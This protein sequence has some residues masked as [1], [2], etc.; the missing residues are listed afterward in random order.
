MSYVNKHGFTFMESLVGLTLFSL[1]LMLYLPAFY[2]E[3]SR[4]SSLQTETQQWQIFQKLV[5]LD[6]NPTVTEQQFSLAQASQSKASSYLVERFACQVDFCFIQFADGE[7]Y[8]VILENI[9]SNTP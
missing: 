8:H 4:I 1:I 5:S 2:L 9:H 3:L 6:L 7:T